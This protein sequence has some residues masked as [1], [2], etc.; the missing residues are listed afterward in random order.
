MWN[1]MSVQSMLKTLDF[2]IM[3]KHE[4]FGLIVT[5]INGDYLLWWPYHLLGM[6]I[7]KNMTTK[8]ALTY[9][10]LNNNEGFSEPLSKQILYMNPQSIPL[11]AN[12]EQ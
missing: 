4:S 9:H 11:P 6:S 3:M 1:K 5:H 10:K 2:G 12:F 7:D 8:S